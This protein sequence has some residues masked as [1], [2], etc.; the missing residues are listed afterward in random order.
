[1]KNISIM[2]VIEQYLSSITLKIRKEYLKN[3][4]FPIGKSSKCF[5]AI[6][7]RNSLEPIASQPLDQ[8]RFYGRIL[9]LF[10][11]RG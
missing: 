5:L 2:R 6:I 7:I 4:G 8:R 10:K 9:G 3:I 1:M 11:N